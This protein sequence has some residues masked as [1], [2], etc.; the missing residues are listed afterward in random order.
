M[1]TDYTSTLSPERWITKMHLYLI[2]KWD[3]LKNKKNLYK[4]T[5]KGNERMSPNGS[6]TII[7]T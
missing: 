7:T 1:V 5:T 4:S 3:V 6:E 2:R